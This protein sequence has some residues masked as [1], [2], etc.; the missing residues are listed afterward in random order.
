MTW[1][2]EQAEY[3]VGREQLGLPGYSV[4]EFHKEFCSKYSESELEELPRESE[5]GVEEMLI[6]HEK[7]ADN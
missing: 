6:E 4:E 7:A 2:K 1:T 5:K 3:S